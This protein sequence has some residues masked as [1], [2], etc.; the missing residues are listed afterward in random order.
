MCCESARRLCRRSGAALRIQTTAQL[1]RAAGRSSRLDGAA[2]PRNVAGT[3]MSTCGGGTGSAGRACVQ[4]RPGTGETGDPRVQPRLP[5]AR[6]CHVSRG[7]PCTSQSGCKRGVHFLLFQG[8]EALGVSIRSSVEQPGR[9][10]L[11]GLVGWASRAGR[12]GVPEPCSPKAPPLAKSRVF[13]SPWS[14]HTTF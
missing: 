4:A 1:C 8:R 11:P 3:T 7:S 12:V 6:P 5:L 13:R 10:G 14:F 2:C 9:P